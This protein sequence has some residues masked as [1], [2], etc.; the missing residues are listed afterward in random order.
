MRLKGAGLLPDYD[1]PTQPTDIRGLELQT[2]KLEELQK[3]ARQVAKEC[4]YSYVPQIQVRRGKGGEWHPI[5]R[6]IRIGVK[7]VRAGGDR[8][9]YF[10][11]H[12]LAHAQANEA[13]GHSLAYWRRLAKGL[14]R[15]GRLD[16]IRLDFG[17]REGALRVAREFGLGN[18]PHQRNFELQI[19]DTVTDE[20]ERQWR[21]VKRFRQAGRPRYRLERPGWRWQ[22]SEEQVL[23][24][25]RLPQSSEG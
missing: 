17:Y 4:G 11:T 12:E 20:D 6:V 5:S 1:A 8:L 7:E 21:V 23:E 18:L 24:K 13:E 2:A 25:A 14:A 15:A 3:L 10:M 19:G 16:L 22:A 9:W